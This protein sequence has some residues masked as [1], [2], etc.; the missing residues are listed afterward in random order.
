MEK[1]MTVEQ[2]ATK[3]FLRALIA[4]VH[5]YIDMT[6]EDVVEEYR[7]AGKLHTYDP[8]TEWQKRYARVARA[9]PRP[10]A[11]WPLYLSWNNTSSSLMRTM[12]KIT[13]SSLMRILNKIRIY[14]SV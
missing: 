8:Y 9:H 1:W 3:T 7:R 11:S 5:Q 2:E 4:D 14:S 10:L 6:E 12:N 13:S